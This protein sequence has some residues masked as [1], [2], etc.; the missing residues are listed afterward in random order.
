[1]RKKLLV[2]LITLLLVFTCALCACNN[3]PKAPEVES[4]TLSKTAI[5]LYVGDE[6]QLEAKV[7]PETASDKSVKWYVGDENVITVHDG[8]V[9]AVG[10]GLTFWQK[11]TTAV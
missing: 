3:N 5:A 4:V 7:L 6:I 8:K 10:V 1:M 11:A 9:T 2:V